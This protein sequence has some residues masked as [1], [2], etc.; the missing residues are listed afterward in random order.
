MKLGLYKSFCLIAVIVLLSACKKEYED[1]EA[2]DAREVQAYIQKNSLAGF[3]QYNNTGLY[4]QVVTQGVGL[5]IAYTDRVFS[6]FTT[7]SLDGTFN[8]SADSLNRF[9]SFLGYF[10]NT[11]GYPEA[12]STIIKEKLKFGGTIR[13]II[14]SHLAYG[15]GG[16]PSLKI[17]GN[18]S[19][20]CTITVY[21]VHNQTAFEDIFVKRYMQQ[22]NITGFSRLPSGLY[23][24]VLTPPGTGV[25]PVEGSAITT[26]YTGKLT[27]GTQFE[28]NPSFKASLVPN[29]IIEGW[30]QGLLLP[31]PTDPNLPNPRVK[32]GGTIRLIIPPSLAYGSQGSGNVPAFATLD[33]T[34]NLLDVE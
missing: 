26:S 19:L 16:N 23:Y 25:Y 14:P 4:Y 1:I 20:D 27:N 2:I 28:Q 24:K 10:N 15:R 11:N 29:E 33:F 8:L 6:T 34:I 12:F 31:L 5:D 13:L 22:N 18:T 17:P 3:Q 32:K 30:L 9:S 7:K 21:D